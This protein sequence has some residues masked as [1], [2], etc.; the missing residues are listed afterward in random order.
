MNNTETDCLALSKIPKD[1]F[2]RVDWGLYGGRVQF[3][4][5]GVDGT[6]AQLGSELPDEVSLRKVIAYVDMEH[7]QL[8]KRHEKS[9]QR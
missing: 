2:D 3:Y 4:I 5:K 6:L 9:K 1:F 8:V 7:K